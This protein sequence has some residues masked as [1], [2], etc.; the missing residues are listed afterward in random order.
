MNKTTLTL[1]GCAFLCGSINAA[2]TI[3]DGI[4]DANVLQGKISTNTTLHAGSDYGIKG[5]VYVMDGATLTIEPGVTVYAD[6]GTAADG[7]ALIITRGGT[8]NAQGTATAP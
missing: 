1:I 6:Q 8:I 5:Y 2:S 4:E 3:M 7:S